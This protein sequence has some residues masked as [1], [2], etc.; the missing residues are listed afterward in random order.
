MTIRLSATGEIATFQDVDQFIPAKTQYACGYFSCAIVKAMAPVG[1]APTQMQA[2]M[3]N[4]AEQ[5]YAQ[6]N[7]DN[8][9]GNQSG[10]TLQQLY[11]LLGQVGLHYQASSTDVRTLRAWLDLGY[12]VLVSG[13]ETGFYDMGLGDVVPYPWQPSG[14]HMIVLTGVTSDD[15]FLVRDPANVTDVNN[16]R[17]LRAGPRKY[18][19]RRMQLNSATAVVP[20]WKPPLP[21]GFDPSQNDFVPVVPSGWHDDGVT[22][23]ASNGHKV[24]GDFRRHVLTHAWGSTNLPLEEENTR[25]PLEESNPSLGSGI[26]QVFNWT[27]LE[28]T[29]TRG[30]FEAWTGQELMKVRADRDALQAQIASLQAQLQTN[31]SL[32]AQLQTKS[33]T[34]A[35]ASSSTPPAIIPKKRPFASLWY[36]VSGI[37]QKKHKD[38]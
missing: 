2:Q 32:H 16:P 5:W 24:I 17:S 23:T 27:T 13:D 35:P 31:S 36:V 34:D 29:E 11:S 26:Q 30:L 37:I 20:I 22:L 19:A 25:N 15:N 9:L 21:T 4:E 33:S 28:W 18:D 3:I 6:Y 7:G 38:L 12:P 10:I 14:S 8:S 1:Q